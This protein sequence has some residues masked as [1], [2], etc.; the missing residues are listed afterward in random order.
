MPA[1]DVMALVLPDYLRTTPLW[2]V[3]S[4]SVCAG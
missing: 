3:L 4:S 1:L 2:R